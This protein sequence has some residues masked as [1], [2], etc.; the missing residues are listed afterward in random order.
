MFHLGGLELCLGELSP[1]KLP[2]G[3]GTAG[4]TINYALY[5]AIHEKQT[6]LESNPYIRPKFPKSPIL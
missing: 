3:D 5:D 1:Q 6:S 2:R 4:R